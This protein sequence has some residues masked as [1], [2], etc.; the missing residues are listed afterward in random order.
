MTAN[1]K[2]GAAVLG[3]YALGRAKKGKLAIALGLWLMGKRI[4]I[5]PRQIGTAIARSPALGGLGG[6]ARENLLE[7]GKSAAGTVLAARADSLAETLHQRTLDLERLKPERPKPDDADEGDQQPEEEA[8]E[9]AEEEM[10]D[11]A[12]DEDTTE[13]D[14]ERRRQPRRK[15]PA[16]TRG[17]GTSSPAGRSRAKTPASG[18][19]TYRRSSSGGRD[20]DWKTGSGTRRSEND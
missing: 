2:V 18:A 20:K 3:G 4:N 17:K 11:T 15:A 8:E 9:E 14:T 12:E 5:D 13:E 7:A 16:P 6:Q 19:P 1:S 10:E